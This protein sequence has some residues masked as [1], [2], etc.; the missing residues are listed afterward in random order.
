M[1]KSLIAFLVAHWL[2]IRVV[3]TF[4][5]LIALFFFLLTYNPIV[6][7]IDI[8]SMLAQVSAWLGWI[9][10]RGLGAVMGFPVEVDGTNLASGSFVVDVGPGCS[11]AVPMMIYLAA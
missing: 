3:T 9:L 10:L 8:A 4:V 2:T 6:K 7:R 11:G 1:L 5:L